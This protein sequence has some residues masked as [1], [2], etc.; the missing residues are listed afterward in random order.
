MDNSKNQLINNNDE[1]QSTGSKKP[2]GVNRKNLKAAVKLVKAESNVMMFKRLVKIRVGTKWK[3][4]HQ[5]M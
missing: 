3:W 4:K 1:E 2:G 5:G